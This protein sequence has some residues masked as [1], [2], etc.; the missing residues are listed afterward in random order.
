MSTP[1]GCDEK[2]S[3]IDGDMVNVTDG[4]G[5]TWKI[6]NQNLFAN[7]P[8]SENPFDIDDLTEITSLE[9]DDYFA[10]LDDTDGQHKKISKANLESEIGGSTGNEI[11]YILLVDAKSQGSYGGTFTSGAR[12]T[13]DLNQ[14]LVDTGGFC[15]LSSNQF[16][17]A[18]GKYILKGSAPAMGVSRHRA[19]L[20][21][22]SDSADEALGSCEYA[23]QGYSA[24]T[25]SFISV[26]I[27]ISTAKTF[28]VQHQCSDT[29]SNNGFGMDSNF[30]GNEYFT[31]VEIWRVGE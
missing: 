31:I 7:L 29:K 16:T 17:L 4:S 19:Y 18:A 9:D 22:V 11:A 14:E 24:Q 5:K 1:L 27:D 28:E 20:Y 21:N 25:R 12:R 6:S 8:I 10:V 23:Y 13:R 15:T 26:Y 3:R 30:G 2:S